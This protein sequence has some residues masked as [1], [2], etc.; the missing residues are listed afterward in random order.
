[1]WR[2]RSLLWG[3]VV[4]L[5]DGRVTGLNTDAG[6]SDEALAQLWARSGE[7]EW[8]IDS[9][10]ISEILG[11]SRESYDKSLASELLIA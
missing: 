6:S 9:Q 8:P 5:A 3:F 7:V 2:P 11:P 4:K 1:M 10:A